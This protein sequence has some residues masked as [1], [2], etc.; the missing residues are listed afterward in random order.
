MFQFSLPG[1]LEIAP[2]CYPVPSS[3][4]CKVDGTEQFL[5]LL[6]L[7]RGQEHV[8]GSQLS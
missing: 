4:T 1:Y 7:M 6:E 8:Q 5:E 3:L 2:V